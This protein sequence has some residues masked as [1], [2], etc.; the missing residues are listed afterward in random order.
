MKLLI[1]KVEKYVLQI[2]EASSRG[3]KVTLNKMRQFAL[4]QHLENGGYINDTSSLVDF[5]N[6]C[7]LKGKL[8]KYKIFFCLEATPL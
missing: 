6:S 1:V 2:A 7:I 5:I 4:P 3:K 8:N